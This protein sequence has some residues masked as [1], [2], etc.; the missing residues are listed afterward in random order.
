MLF[1]TS[2]VAVLALAGA[3]AFAGCSSPSSSS[4]D[5]AHASGTSQA[6]PTATS[7]AKP[8]DLTGEW[9]QENAGDAYQ[10][11]KVTADSISVDWVDTKGG[12]TSVYWVG[13]YEA[14]TNPGPFTWTS[15]RDAA[16]TDRALLASTEPTKEFR[17]AE[18]KISY[19]VSMMGVTKAMTL[20]RK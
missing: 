14:P 3:L 13:T 9:I 18:D 4:D 12:T 20:V 16:A 5:G 6:A 17:Y 11:A 1:R 7:Q 8:A 10:S 2:T 15:S 19:E